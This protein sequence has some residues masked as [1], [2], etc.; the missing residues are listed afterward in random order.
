MNILHI[1]HSKEGDF[2][3]YRNAI[4]HNQDFDVK[5]SYEKKKITIIFKLKR[6][7]KDEVKWKKNVK[8]DLD[9]FESLFRRFRKFQSLIISFYKVYIKSFDEN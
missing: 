7:Y 2:L 6:K 9:E 3:D 4:K 8:M 1:K 5:A